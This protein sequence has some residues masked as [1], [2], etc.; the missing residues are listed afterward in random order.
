MKHRQLGKTGIHVSEIGFGGW[1]I[2]GLMNSSGIPL[3]WG[4]VKDQESR[5]AIKKAVE[6]GIN[7]FDTSD[8][9][10]NGHS[11]ELLGECLKGTD[12]FIATKVGI[13]DNSEKGKD[14]SETY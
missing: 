4:V 8:F 12:C 14:F 2:G 13:R 3:G 5:E 6:L 10:G 9:Y 11:E 1:A 7:F